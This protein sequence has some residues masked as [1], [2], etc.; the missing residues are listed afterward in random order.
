MVSVNAAMPFGGA[1]DAV[2]RAG[3]SLSEA[4]VNDPRLIEQPES[5]MAISTIEQDARGPERAAPEKG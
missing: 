2:D 4:G 1:I 5:A 3:S